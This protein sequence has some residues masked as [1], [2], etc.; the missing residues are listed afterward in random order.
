MFDAIILDIG[1]GIFTA[2]WAVFCKLPM[3][4]LDLV[5]KGYGILALELPSTMLFGLKPGQAFSEA[6]I[7]TLFTRLAI[8][9]VVVFGIMFLVAIIKVGTYNPSKE[10][11]P[12]VGALKYSAIGSLFI[13]MIPLVLFGFLM[14]MNALITLILGSDVKPLS[15]IMWNSLYSPLKYKDISQQLWEAQPLTN[16]D[17]IGGWTPDKDFW[18]KLPNGGGFE[19]IFTF[20][21]IIT[22]TLI[23]LGIGSVTLVQKIFQQLVLFI[24][25]PFVAAS[26][27]A[28]DGKRLRLWKDQFIAKSFV[29]VGFVLGIQIFSVF[30]N[31]ALQSLNLISAQ[32][33]ILKLLLM[34]AIFC[35]GGIAATN[36]S[37]IFASFLGE[38][39]SARETLGETKGLIQTGLAIGGA[40]LAGGKL[41]KKAVGGTAKL[42]AKVGSKVAS[43]LQSVAQ[44]VGDGDKAAVFKNIARGLGG[45]V[46]GA[47]AVKAAEQ[48]NG[49]KLNKADKAK[50]KE[51]AKA[52]FNA[53]QDYNEESREKRDELR[54]KTDWTKLQEG[55]GVP[56]EKRHQNITKRE[57][58]KL[59]KEF[60]EKNK[61]NENLYEQKD[62]AYVQALE[63]YLD[64]NQ[65]AKFAKNP[66]SAR[67]IAQN[68]KY[69]RRKAATRGWSDAQI[70]SYNSAIAEQIEKDP[71]LDDDGKANKLKEHQ[72]KVANITA[73]REYA[74]Y[75]I[76]RKEQIKK[77]LETKINNGGLS[78]KERQHRQ[79]ILNPTPTEDEKEDTKQTTSNSTTSNESK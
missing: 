39:A 31:L 56:E 67:K 49:G 3:L 70:L 10:Q 2:L 43:G 8:I 71:S 57:A 73:R 33:F 32:D 20:L 75:D 28:D 7:P 25:S 54:Y 46:A 36:L 63:Q 41:L 74:S 77:E 37:Q 9:S 13:I 24:I 60:Y 1:Y 68:L 72:Q 26:G 51:E 29:I 30:V 44:A 64:A 65:E 18:K 16:P 45:F 69:N 5:Q 38:S 21:I 59:V 58:K 17:T 23:P 12:L 27:V 35:G 55:A 4:M 52:N 22:V 15:H 34:I 50:I 53:E 6:V 47:A 19:I 14:V 61:D 11:N 48:A 42:G 66:N 79:E 40:A 78:E 76:E 62:F